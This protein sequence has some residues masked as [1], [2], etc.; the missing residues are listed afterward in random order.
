[1]TFNVN[2]PGHV[3]EHN[4]LA[5]IL[6]DGFVP[7]T[8][9]N[10]DEQTAQLASVPGSA[11]GAQLSA[12]IGAQITSTV[13]YTIEP[14]MTQAQIQAVFTGAVEGSIIRFL[15]G[16]YA[17]T[18]T[19]LTLT[20]DGIY[21]DA[22]RATITQAT[23]G[24]PAFDLIGRNNMTLDIGTV[25]FVGTRGGQGTSFRGSA[26]YCSGAAV[27]INGDHN[28]VRS[29]TS[30]NMA[31]G[32]FLSAWNGSTTYDHQ[33]VGN[34]IGRI[35]VSGMDWGV[36]WS[37]QSG[38][39]IEDIYAH[40]DTD[41]SAGANPTHAL[42][43]SATTTYRDSGVTVQS[44]RAKNIVTGQ[45]VQFKYSDNLRVRNITADGCKGVLNLIDCMNAD[46]DG[47]TATG[48][49][50]NA[51]AGAF[52][53]QSTDEFSQRP[54]VANVSIQLAAN[55]DEYGIMAI[56]DYG[57]WSNISV[58]S[59][60]SGSVTTSVSD[61][62]IRGTGN[63]Y[64]DVRNS[65][66][67]GAAAAIRV[68]ATATPGNSTQIVHPIVTGAASMV[69]IVGGST[70]VLIDYDPTAQTVASFIVNALGTGTET[71]STRS[72]RAVCLTTFGENSALTLLA[73]TGTITVGAANSCLQRK[74]RPTR[75]INVTG[76]V[77]FSAT[78]SGNY[79]IAI[80]DDASNAKLWS[81]GSTAWPAAG[82]ITETVTSVTLY[83]GRTYRL[84]FSGDNATGAVRGSSAAF[85]GLDVLLDGTTD[86]TTVA[87]VFPLPSTLVAGTA[88]TTRVPLIAVLG[89]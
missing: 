76:L 89:S 87:S 1:M 27:W 58:E 85:A 82:K 88:A 35:E 62:N 78:Q 34:R 56:S 57:V 4:R 49:L 47:V 31:V 68:G 44:V 15:A 67:G 3:A 77:W 39:V 13:Q 28:Y 7:M 74:V 48:C 53:M 72:S 50:A 70:G 43:G 41:D 42:Y 19:G 11:L 30:V 36:L 59:N 63:V 71:W 12:T 2:S 25:Q 5:G 23:W 60:H 45:A 10:L 6:P 29:L 17:L 80:Y 64:T 20:N 66:L 86:S 83:A 32:V 84:V 55:V 54:R 33:G 38:L 37:W 75:T 69:S 52:T 18:G 22:S 40:D 61:I 16:T 81:K 24:T 73:A 8:T 9:E 51:G 46:I 14:S 26:G 79:D 65:Q 21:I